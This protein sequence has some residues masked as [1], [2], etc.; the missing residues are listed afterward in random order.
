LAEAS[1]R[2]YSA[3]VIIQHKNGHGH[4]WAA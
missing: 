4:A 1:M 2:S 3:P